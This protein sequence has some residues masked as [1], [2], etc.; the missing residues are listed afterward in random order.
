M[1]KFTSSSATDNAT[2]TEVPVFSTVPGGKITSLTLLQKKVRDIL[3]L[4]DAHFFDIFPVM[5]ELSRDNIIEIMNNVLENKDIVNEYALLSD[6]HVYLNRQHNFHLL[7]RLVGN[8]S[9]STLSANEF[10]TFVINPMSVPLSIPL[11]YSP[12]DNEKFKTPAT[13][14]K[15]ENIQLRPG[16]IYCFE[17]YK[18][19]LDFDVA[20]PQNAFVL[21][22]H[23]EPRDWLSWVYDRTTLEPIESI[24]TNLQASRIQMYIRLL[25]AMKATA[26]IPTLNLLAKSRYANFIRWEAV[27]S[28]AKIAPEHTLSLLTYLV[29]NDPDDRIIQ[30]AE[31]SLEINRTSNRGE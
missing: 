7:M 26:A 9:T 25:G 28:L 3:R 21:I 5:Q 4:E 31:Q 16:K 24:C 30:A 23:S 17:A 11:Y 20:A 1:L 15:Q 8:K 27:E 18:Y 2:M 14:R 13:L 6:D 29:R 22:A 12:I 19:I 10:D